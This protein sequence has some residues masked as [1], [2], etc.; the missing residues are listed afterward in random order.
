MPELLAKARLEHG[1]VAVEGTPR[2]LTVLV[3]GLAARQPD[4][5]ERVRGPPA[6]V[7]MSATCN[8]FVH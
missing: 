2:R 6:K 7:W 3:S 1:A 8:V 5:E 4:A